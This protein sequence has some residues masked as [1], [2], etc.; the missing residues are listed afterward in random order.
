MGAAPGSSVATAA[1]AGDEL[2]AWMVRYGPALRAY[3]AKKVGPGEADDL[4]QEVFLSLQDRGHVEDIQH[5]NRY[6]FRAAANLLTRRAKAKTWDWAD[7]A[8]L[9]EL[10]LFDELSPERSL[11]AKQDLRRMMEALQHLPPRVEEAF[12]L[13]RFED[14]TY[15]EIAQRMG[16]KPKSVE[17]LIIRALEKIAIAMEG[18]DDDR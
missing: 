1:A 11:I 9:E 10:Q 8:G 14:M 4:V 12:V 15:R 5:A 3:F 6:L 16:I 17:A 2:R 13:H 7:S 18:P